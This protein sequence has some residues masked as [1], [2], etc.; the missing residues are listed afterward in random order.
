M[1][2]KTINDI[3]REV[4]QECA[5]EHFDVIFRA[6]IMAGDYTTAR[7]LWNKVGDLYIKQFETNKLNE[8][9]NLLKSIVKK[10]EIISTGPD[11]DNPS[12][13]ISWD[14]LDENESDLI[15]KILK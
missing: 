10:S 11:D 1:K 12:L 15:N 6:E 9:Y 8:Q 3:M 2:I 5:E 7:L 4:A 13:K 14:S